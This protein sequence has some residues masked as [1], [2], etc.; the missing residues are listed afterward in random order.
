MKDGVRWMR[1]TIADIPR[2][3]EEKYQNTQKQEEQSKKRKRKE[4]IDVESVNMPTITKVW[5]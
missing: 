1:E 4:T 2:K 5:L 3:R